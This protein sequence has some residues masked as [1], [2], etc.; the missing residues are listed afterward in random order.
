MSTSSQI[1]SVLEYMEKEKGI[2]R[3]DMIET[4]GEAIRT[5]ALKSITAGQDIRVEINPRTGQLKAWAIFEVV[6][7]VCDPR[8][9]MH[10]SKA[11]AIDGNAEVGSVIETEIDPA[12]LGR[13]VAQTARQAIM[14]RIKFFEKEKLYDDFKNRVGDIASCVVQRVDNGNVYVEIGNTEALLPARECIRGEEYTPGDRIRCLLLKLNTDSRDADIILSRSHVNFVRRLL[15]IEVSEIA[16]GSV[17]IK[18]IARE[19]GYRTKICVDT[20]DKNIDPVGACVGTR[21]VRIKSIVRELNGEK[22][23]VIRYYEDPQKLLCEAIKPA[24]PKNVS[25]D[26][27]EHRICFEVAESDLA[28]AIGKRGLNAKLTSKMMNWRLDISKESVAVDNFD[29]KMERAISGWAGIP[30][31]TKEIAH[32]L[33]AAGITDAEAFESVEPQDLLDAGFSQLEAEQ[34]VQCIREFFRK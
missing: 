10:I 27:S 19:P 24:I 11:M 29:D 2:G 9:Q 20:K 4:I 21:G 34:V 7:S 12:L 18:G 22:I 13:I 6:D 1:L 15:E 16:D 32:K 17:I 3:A 25:I 23:D 31:I 28:V 30:G 33:V 8:N 5:A 14:Q 26:E